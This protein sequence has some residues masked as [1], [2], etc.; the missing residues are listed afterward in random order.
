MFRMPIEK[1]I[2]CLNAKV[3]YSQCLESIGGPALCTHSGEL[4]TE[5]T[6]DISP[7][8]LTSPFARWLRVQEDVHLAALRPLTVVILRDPIQT[9]QSYNMWVDQFDIPSKLCM[10]SSF[11]AVFLKQMEFFR[12]P[13]ISNSYSN[14]L[15]NLRE[16]NLLSKDLDLWRD[17]IVA[18]YEA[19]T[20]N[21]CREE[22][23]GTF[24][25]RYLYVLD[26]LYEFELLAQHALMSHTHFLVVDYNVL[27][28]NPNS[29]RDI[30]FSMLLGT[31]KYTRIIHQHGMPSW[32]D[33]KP[34]NSRSKSKCSRLSCE[35]VFNIRKFLEGP[36]ASLF[37][38]LNNAVDSG[39]ITLLGSHGR[40]WWEHSEIACM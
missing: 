27:V 19:S 25:L 22:S 7:E 31:E 2:G 4:I 20:F 8:P 14:I 32:N 37:E 21:L 13:T 36:T 6:L 26:I 38:T 17:D 24:A 23:S 35:A 29:I 11:E 15:A 30:L 3:N 18:N 1:E 5:M 34:T 39:G 33:V 12:Q 16:R 40:S 10:K 28:R 9:A